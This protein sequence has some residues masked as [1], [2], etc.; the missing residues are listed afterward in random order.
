MSDWHINLSFE[1][2]KG[3]LNVSG[4]CW[5]GRHLISLTRAATQNF[6]PLATSLL[7]AHQYNVHL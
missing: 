7:G 2:A 4:Q 3:F 6:L 1:H 5:Q